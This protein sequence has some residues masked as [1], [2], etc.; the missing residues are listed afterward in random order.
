MS[1]RCG[2]ALM[3]RATDDVT[4]TSATRGSGGEARFFGVFACHGGA[5][6]CGFTAHGTCP[7][8]CGGARVPKGDYADSSP[9]LGAALHGLPTLSLWPLN[10]KLLFGASRS[11]AVA[12]RTCN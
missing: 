1:S 3:C 12:R 11:V 2:S 10:Y 7:Q 9:A 4:D 5:G 6:I 8:S